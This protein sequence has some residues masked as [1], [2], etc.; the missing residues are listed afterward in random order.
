MKI[1]QD[2]G[3]YFLTRHFSR[4]W[5]GVNMLKN[6]VLAGI[7]RPISSSAQLI[8]ALIEPYEVP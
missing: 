6:G 7:N 1:V 3:N 2:S 8:D 5:G 4:V